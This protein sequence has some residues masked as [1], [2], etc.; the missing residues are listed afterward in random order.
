MSQSLKDKT[1]N[2][3][4]WSSVE[5]FSTQ[6][7]QFI[8]SILIARLLAPSDYGVVAML[9]IFLGVSQAFID[10]GFSS[11]II[12]K[13]DRTDVDM[14]TVYYF[15]IA[16]AIFFYLALW[17]A[18]PY[19]AAFY[20]IPLLETI[21]KV[22]SSTL[23]I[24]A[25]AGIHGAQLS[26]NIN[27]KTRAKIS[28][29]CVCSTG[30]VGLLMAY[31]GYGVWALVVQSVVGSLLNT[32]LLWYFV[33][34]KPLLVFS[35]K[36]FKDM[37]S[38]GS[39]MLASGLLDTL[40]N[41]V[42][43]IVIGKVFSPTILG[44][45]GKANSLASFPSSNLTGVLQSVTFPV[46][47]KIQDQDERLKAAYRQMI[48]ISAFVIFPL[49]VGLA[50]VAEPFIRIVFTDKWEGA[51]ILLQIVCFAMMWYPIHAINLNILIVKGRSDFFLRLEIVKKILGVLIL[52]ATLPFGIV[53]MCY[54]R[55]AG[56]L[57]ALVVNTYYT[58]KTI[59]Y[60]IFSQI[61]DLSHII[62]HSLVMGVLAW[63]TVQLMPTMWLKLLGGV[64][65]GGAYYLLGAY[66][67]R[68]SEFEI[69]LNIVKSKLWKRH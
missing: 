58:R 22:V 62:L 61:K 53:V 2:G 29:A 30:I 5:R 59:D 39:R 7:I 11:A 52:C 42:Y 51:I 33:R 43:T 3:V 56:S 20:D 44:L 31:K 14:S 1:V 13:K 66:M 25:F 6:G 46:L 21:T 55:I 28:I 24:S 40:Y 18:S 32:I 12:R 4:L 67:L 23:V 69:L 17:F 68:F 54:G 57:T 45:Y 65:V 34:W 9:G 48:R 60:G 47:C 26:I 36:S 37:F 19:I 15:N 16:V 49:M 38:F 50:A 41:N 8:F 27:F 35:M 63:G 64:V 10:S